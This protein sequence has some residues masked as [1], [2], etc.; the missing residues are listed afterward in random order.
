MTDKKYY[1][2]IQLKVKIYTAGQVYQNERP[3]IMFKTTIQNF[4]LPV[5]LV[6]V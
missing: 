4:R 1:T 6:M 3:Q 2:I 5:G